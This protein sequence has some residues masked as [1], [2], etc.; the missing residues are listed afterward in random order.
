MASLDPIS[1]TLGKERA[2]HLLRRLTFG[3]TRK[4]IDLFAT[5][6]IDEALVLL[7]ET[8]PAPEPPIDPVSGLPF[9]T[10]SPDVSGQG[11]LV[12]YFK[13]WLYG[14]MLKSGTNSIEKLTFFLHTHFTAI[15]DVIFNGSDLY[16]QNQLLRKYALGNFKELALKICI[17]NGMLTLLDNKLNENTKTNENFA[18]EFLELYTIGKG[19]EIGP[20]NYTTYSEQDV[21][22]AAKVLSGWDLDNKTYSSIDPDTGLPTGKMKLNSALLANKHDASTKVFSAAFQNR[23]IT[24]NEIVTGQ[25]DY[26]TEAAARQEI[27]DLVD[28]I[29]AQQATALNICR[30]IYRF[31]VFYNITPEVESNVI[32]PL[33][34]TFIASNFEIKPV[35]DQLLKSQHFFDQDDTVTANNVNGAIIKSPLEVTIGTMRFFNVSLPDMYTD[36]EKFYELVKGVLG[37]I[38]N[39]GMDFYNPLDVAGYDAY[40]QAPG[41]NRNWIS[42]N[43]LARRYQFAQYLIEGRFKT[44]DELTTVQLDPLAYLNEPGNISDPSSGNAVA[45]EILDYLLPQ[46][47]STERY[48]FFLNEVLLDNLPIYEWNMEWT[49]Y[50]TTGDDMG[51]RMQLNAFLNAVLQSAEYQLS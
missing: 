31:F 37:S 40:F 35:L 14:Q 6:S 17:D 44:V 43:Y 36:Y 16:Y 41:Y 8:R 28:M 21:Q 22:A 10:F 9:T 27:K 32:G 7:F 51:V 23:Q 49:K 4:E 39:Q 45:N 30:K 25:E 11:D 50:K 48:N 13:A 24:P 26:A 19:L 38:F 33:A 18:R 46:N 15:A 34:Q 42:P 2:A 47:I 20:G 5:K 29:F 1:G 12:N 3:A